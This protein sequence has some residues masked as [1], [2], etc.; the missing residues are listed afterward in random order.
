MVTRGGARLEEPVDASHRE[1][2]SRTARSCL[3]LARA[4]EI[5]EI[6]VR[7][8]GLLLLFQLPPAF[9]PSSRPCL[10]VS[11]GQNRN[12]SFCRAGCFRL[13]PI[14]HLR[15]LLPPSSLESFPGTDTL[16]K[17]SKC[18]AFDQVEHGAPS[19]PPHQP[20]HQASTLFPASERTE[21]HVDHNGYGSNCSSFQ[22]PLQ[23]L[24]TRCEPFQRGSSCCIRISFGY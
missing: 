6:A 10:L 16:R 23:F 19:G 12:A 21:R 2:A 5:T 11:R 20:L 1:N 4:T 13:V 8:L 15:S 24:T 17:L 22:H 14:L 18:P 9:H 3:A 7:A